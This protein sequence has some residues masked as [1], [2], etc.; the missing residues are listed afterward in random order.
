MLRAIIL[1]AL[2]VV[3]GLFALLNWTAFTTP[4]TLSLLFADVQAPL[5]LIML[6][7][8]V[9]LTLLFTLWAI[10]LQA[11]TL[12]EAR[13]QNRELQAQRDLADKAE[14]S[15]FVE[16]R[17]YVGTELERTVSASNRGH[18]ELLNRLNH[19]EGALRLALEQNANAVA[20]SLGEFEDRL[21]R[22]DLPPPE[23]TSRVDTTPP[24]RR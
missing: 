24:L 1:F 13:R 4:T 11:S 6:G 12:L 23:I 14:A 10:S 8:V 5:G 15:R 17:S 20:A 9:F 21:E 7:M 3:I 2:V 18:E 16:L 19:L 22:G